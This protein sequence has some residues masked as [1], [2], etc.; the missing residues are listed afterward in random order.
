MRYTWVEKTGRNMEGKRRWRR[1]KKSGARETK[2]TVGQ[3]AEG[4]M[5]DKKPKPEGDIMDMLFL[6]DH[7]LITLYIILFLNDIV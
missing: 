4:H 6:T 7:L 5:R 1:N 2:L 3:K